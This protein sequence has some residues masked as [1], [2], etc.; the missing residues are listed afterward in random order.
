MPTIIA[1]TSVA[2]TPLPTW[3]VP[4]D[5]DSVSNTIECVGP[6]ADGSNTFQGGAG[7]GGAYAKISSLALT[8][9]DSI[10]YNA[11]TRNNGGGGAT[12]C[13]FNGPNF[14]GA[15]VGAVRGQGGNSSGIGGL[16]GDAAS[17]IGTVTFSGGNGGNGGGGEFA[18][19]GGGGG[20]AGPFGNGGNGAN[21]LGPSSAVSG[22]GGGGGG[23][24]N[25]VTT[26]GGNN[27]LGTG[28]GATN[29]DGTDGGGGG[30]S[31]IS[32][33]LPGRGGDGIEWP[34]VSAGSGGGG[35]GGG[36]AGSGGSPCPSGG[37]YGG[38]GG[39]G[40]VYN[41]G[42]EGIQGV[43]IITYGPVT[44]PEAVAQSIW[45]DT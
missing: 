6:G 29:V 19:G 32:N 36:G 23:G 37:L 31:L 17:C 27:H 30:G 44:P 24:S 1:L 7:G 28:G 40:S 20:A 4:A 8:P 12:D 26:T 35:G 41:T 39:G 43:I 9:G 25:A 3:T 15:S 18:G 33:S 11:G 38:G 45:I 22:A 13:W 16:G 34:S 10:T 14:A 5:W 42:G 21:G 2:T